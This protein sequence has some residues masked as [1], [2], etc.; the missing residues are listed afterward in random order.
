MLRNYV[1]LIVIL[2][3]QAL[4]LKRRA[5]LPVDDSFVMNVL[6]PRS[7]V[8]GTRYHRF[9]VI[10]IL[11]RDQAEAIQKRG[12]DHLHWCRIAGPAEVQQ[13]EAVV[14]DLVTGRLHYTVNGRFDET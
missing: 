4:E 11:R 1:L 14:M 7:H 6:D 12:R 8:L 9:V 2:H 13:T 5:M 3:L 10:P